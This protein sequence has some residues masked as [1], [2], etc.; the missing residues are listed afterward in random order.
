V[1]RRHVANGDEL[2]VDMDLRLSVFTPAEFGAK[3]L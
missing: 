2:A 3:T 1:S